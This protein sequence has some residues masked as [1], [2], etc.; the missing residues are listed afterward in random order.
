MQAIQEAIAELDGKITEL[1]T[2]R[3]ALLV[4]APRAETAAAVKGD[5][6]PPARRTYKRR[7]GT[8][9]PTQAK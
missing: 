6:M 8:Q 4:I 2:A 7:A 3:D 5:A 1:T 9:E